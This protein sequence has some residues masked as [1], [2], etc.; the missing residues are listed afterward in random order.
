V[1]VGLDVHKDSIHAGI[2]RPGSE[3]GELRALFNDEY[4]VRN[5]CARALGPRGQVRVCHEAGPTGDGLARQLRSLG[6]ACQ[7]I[8]PSLI[9]KAPGEEAVRDLCRA[10]AD[11]VERSDPGPHR[12]DQVPA[13]PRPHLGGRIELVHS[14]PGLAGSPALSRSGPEARLRPLSGHPASPT[15]RAR[16][17][18]RRPRP[19]SSTGPPSPIP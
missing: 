2:L 7:V 4:S 11:M 5:F 15:M 19:S 17:G 10:R 9:P 1:W 6:G 3:S 13:A 12:S 8:A 16:G 18:Q 14:P